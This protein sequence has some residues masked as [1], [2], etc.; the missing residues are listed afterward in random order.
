MTS[1]TITHI[2]SCTKLVTAIAV[3]QLVETG[4]ISLDDPAMVVKHLPEVAAAKV[5]NREDG[6]FKFRAPRNKITVRMLL[7]HTSGYGYSVR[8]SS[9]TR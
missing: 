6:I 5:V 1:D 2:L 8:I 7:N 9:S 3:L 4:K